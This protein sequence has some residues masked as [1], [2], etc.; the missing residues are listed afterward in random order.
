LAGSSW[1]SGFWSGCR[2]LLQ[3]EGALFLLV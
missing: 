2:L 3:E 1:R